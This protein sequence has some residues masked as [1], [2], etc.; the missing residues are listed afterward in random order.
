MDSRL[1]SESHPEPAGER[2]V[3][4]SARIHFGCLKTQL[5]MFTCYVHLNMNFP[6]SNCVL[7]FSLILRLREMLHSGIRFVVGAKL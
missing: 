6:S 1:W 5:A 7:T 4:L 2:Q 3:V